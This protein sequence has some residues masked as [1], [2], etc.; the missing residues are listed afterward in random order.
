MNHHPLDV[1]VTIKTYAFKNSPFPVIINLECHC[2]LDQQKKLA[3]ILLATLGRMILLPGEMLADFPES[4]LPSP[5]EL[6]YKFL[7][8]GRRQQDAE[9]ETELDDD[10]DMSEESFKDNVTSHYRSQKRVA[11]NMHPDLT[12][13]MYLNTTKLVTPGQGLELFCDKVANI[14]EQ[15]CAQWLKNEQI[16]SDWINYNANHIW[17]EII[18]SF[19]VIYDVISIFANIAEYFRRA[20]VWI[21]RI[22][23]LLCRGLQAV[24]LSL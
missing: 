17:Y 8:R 13:L 15:K 22:W 1:M 6:R 10:E 18:P 4:Q 24:N 11:R 21:R 20:L 14:S 3:D 16:L 2:S 9:Q 7:I 19:S 5:S 23:T 12:S